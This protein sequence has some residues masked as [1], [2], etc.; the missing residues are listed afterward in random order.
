MSKDNLL[1][2]GTPVKTDA[3]LLAEM[4]TDPEAWA[5]ELR[6]VMPLGGNIALTAAWFH[7][8]IEAGRATAKPTVDADKPKR[9]PVVWGASGLELRALAASAR[10]SLARLREFIGFDENE[11]TRTAFDL[12][13]WHLGSTIED[14]AF[15]DEA[16][17]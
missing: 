8:A 6:K 14:P 3:E 16:A 12:V 5:R 11:D 1:L 7:H 2:R 4:G 15:R 10:A 9:S 17:A 13:D